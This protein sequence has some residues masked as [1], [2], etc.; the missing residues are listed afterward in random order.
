MSHFFHRSICKPPVPPPSIQDPIICAFLIAFA[1]FAPVH[2]NGIK[3]HPC[4]SKLKVS[5]FQ[6]VSEANA[7]WYP[8]GLLIEPLATKEL[9]ASRQV[10][11]AKWFTREKR[12]APFPIITIYSNP[13]QKADR[14]G[15]KALLPMKLNESLQ[16]YLLRQGLARADINTLS[17]P[18]AKHFLEIEAE[19][20]QSRLGLWAHKV[21]QL[22]NARSLHL[23]D[24]VSTYQL[25]VGTIKSISRNPKRISYL[26]FGNY[27]KEDFTVTLS[28]RS[29]KIWEQQGHSLDEL[30]G[31]TVYVRGWIENRDGALIRIKHP[32]QLQYKFKDQVRE[33]R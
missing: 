24:K 15:R 9:N 19:A 22:R 17:L 1:P 25:V 29:L 13:K 32:Q 33:A 31:Q 4:L 28:A 7:T 6:S 5:K 14:F 23:S 2:A 10:A 21:Y 18:C 16:E 27:W 20:R 12:P 8:L 30:K 26:N 11:A 3:Q